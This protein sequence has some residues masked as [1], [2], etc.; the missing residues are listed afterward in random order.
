MRPDPPKQRIVVPNASLNYLPGEVV[1]ANHEMF[2]FN[3][4]TV[5]LR[6]HG[7]VYR[8]LHVTV[9]ARKD[10]VL[11]AEQFVNNDD[12]L[13]NALRYKPREVFYICD[14]PQGQRGGSIEV[15]W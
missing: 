5:A 2:D 10:V 3:D 11:E 9:A 6:A 15:T 12:A 4:C 14:T 1:L 13:F 8:A 7:T